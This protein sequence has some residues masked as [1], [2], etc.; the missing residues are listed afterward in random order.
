MSAFLDS[1]LTLELPLE[2]GAERHWIPS[3]DAGTAE[4]IEKMRSLVDSGKRSQRV[5][6]LA[7]RLI[8][9]CTKKDYYCYAD[10]IFKF[11]RDKI[12]Y[13]YDPHGVEW[14]ESPERILDAGVADCDSVCVLFASLC[15]NLGLPCQYVTV[16][17][18]K[19][20]P[21]EFSHVYARVKIPGRGWIAADCTMQHDFGWEPTGY[22]EK[23]WPASHTAQNLEELDG[24]G[25]LR[26]MRDFAAEDFSPF[27]TREASIE[28][29]VLC[30]D[31][32][33]VQPEPQTE[34]EFFIPKTPTQNF[35]T[36]M[37]GNEEVAEA[38]FQNVIS[39]EY[40]RDLIAIRRNQQARNGALVTM[41]M[42]TNDPAKKVQVRAVAVANRDALKTTMA[43][44]EQYNSIVLKI[45][46]YSFGQVKPQVLS[47]LG[48]V[49]LALIAVVGAAGAVVLTGLLASFA[50]VMYAVNGKE[51]KVKGMFENISDSVVGSA[52]LVE[53]L[54]YAALI[55]AGI[56]F[57]VQFLKS[58]QRSTSTEL[59]V[60]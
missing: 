32:P 34:S 28:E 44:I 57:A 35:L 2:K 39:G 23:T 29:A 18:D 40:G 48:V 41:E 17:A 13:A 12:Q 55:G 59:K 24:I 16:R 60:F 4:T 8:Q 15:E 50:N 5:R 31:C 43:A 54:T 27:G 30:A 10:S 19:N 56:Y 6:E 38:S 51:T 52:K 14:V 49:P 37:S 25:G 1:L 45:R 7:G 58:R 42:K 53:N 11:C 47:G 33:Q 20:R 21:S 46:T 26:G 22:P 9:S 3:G 36:G